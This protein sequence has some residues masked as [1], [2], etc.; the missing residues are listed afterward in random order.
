ME[1]VV[2][3]GFLEEVSL[4][5]KGGQD[6]EV[7]SHFRP[8]EQNEH[9]RGGQKIQET[10]SR[11]EKDTKV[12]LRKGFCKP[13]SCSVAFHKLSVFFFFFNCN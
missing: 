7:Q 2:G 4:I 11:K 12:H 3:E 6:S 5:L 1:Q 13:R 9:R 10:A 8:R